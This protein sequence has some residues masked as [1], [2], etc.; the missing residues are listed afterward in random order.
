MIEQR[1]DDPQR[2]PGEKE[3]SPG[4]SP[5]K[6]RNPGQSPGKEKQPGKAPGKEKQ[7][8]REKKSGSDR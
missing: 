4:Q 8:G 3:K 1:R 6:E 2:R 5:G 7:P